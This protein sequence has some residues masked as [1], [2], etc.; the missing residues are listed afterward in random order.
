[1]AIEYVELVRESCPPDICAWEQERSTKKEQK[2][3]SEDE[4]MERRK[5]VMNHS[6]P[7]ILIYNSFPSYLWLV[8]PDLP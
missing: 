2:T 6:S 8:R 7:L 1:M 5:A 4:I 3:A